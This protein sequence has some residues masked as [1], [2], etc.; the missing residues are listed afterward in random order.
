MSK[1]NCYNC[2]RHNLEN[3][4]IVNITVFLF[5]L[6]TVELYY[7]TVFYYYYYYYEGE[8]FTRNRGPPTPQM[9]G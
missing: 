9:V 2:V 5:I 7:S 6:V 8:G 1:L 4:S 3:C